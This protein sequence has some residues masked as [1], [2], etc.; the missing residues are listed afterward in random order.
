MSV[1]AP[2]GSSLSNPD[3]APVPPQQRTWGVWTVAALWVGMAVC[4]PTYM[5]AAG[6]IT[7]GMSWQQAIF[8]IALGNL[9]VCVPMVL[10]AHP[11]TRYGIPFPVLL[12]ASFGV[13]GAHIAAVMRALVACGWF[14]IQTWI[15]GWAIYTLHSVIFDFQPAGPADVLPVLGLSW[16]QL[17]CFLLFWAANVALILF[18]IDSIKWLE[19][20]AAPFLIFVG[21]GL[22]LWSVRQAGGLA[23]VLSPQ[24]VAKVRGPAGG[25][26][27]FWKAFW[28]NLTAMVGFWA[29][30]ALNIAEFS[31][32]CRRQRDQVLGQ[33]LGL[34]P[35]MT[36]YSFI[37]VAVTCATVVIFGEAI[38]DPVALLA[39]FDNVLLVSFALFALTIATLTTNL[40]ANVV[41]PANAFSNLWP[42]AIRFRT[43]ALITAVIGVVILPWK[44]YSDL[45]NYI[46]T[47][48]IGYSALLGA[49]A[50][51]M[52]A[53]YYLVRRCVLNLDDLYRADGE[54]A[55]G[56]SGFN[57]RAIVA[58]LIG[59]LPNVPGFLAQAAGQ[60]ADGA[61]RID[62]PDLFD[63][64]YTYAWFVGLAVAGAVH[65]LLTMVLP[66]PR[67]RQPGNA[68]LSA[69]GAEPPP[70]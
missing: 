45:S 69:A 21:L 1:D 14:G 17:G 4:I 67:V 50:G 38:W 46:F 52:L 6:L 8:T 22:L 63:T 39:R 44:L 16:G 28:P 7:Q 70:R 24:T 13:R 20:L 55:F 2:A 15:G 56:G 26:F 25:Q 66:P 23:V 37:G 62:V 34:P 35:T 60:N 40:A 57:W 32:Y 31:R 54:Y 49:I 29:T 58:M 10:N 30:L 33:L 43:G 41:A 61:P 27:E 42:R 36:L 12:R 11:G 47:W 19:R 65:L 53:D 18:G 48:L 68:P 3:L 51:V 5:L 59:I 9:I 64:L